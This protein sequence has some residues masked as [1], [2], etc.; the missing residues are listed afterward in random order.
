VFSSDAARRRTARGTQSVARRESRIAP[1]I[2]CFA[3]ALNETPRDGSNRS[4]ASMSPIT[5]VDTRSSRS[6]PLGE[7]GVR[8]PR[9]GAGQGIVLGDE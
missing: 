2:R 8:A 7:P 3:Y 9:D 4:T 5:A 1:W 6:T